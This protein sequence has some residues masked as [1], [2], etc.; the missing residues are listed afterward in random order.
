[1]KFSGKMCLMIMLKVTKSH[2]FNHALENTVFENL[3]VS[4]F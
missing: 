1:M 3:R 4:I 2:G